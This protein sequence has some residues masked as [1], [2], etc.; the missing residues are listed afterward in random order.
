MLDEVKK[1]DSGRIR[2]LDGTG[3][4][5]AVA[6]KW[7]DGDETVITLIGARGMTVFESKY[8]GRTTSTDYP[9]G[10]LQVRVNA[11]GEGKGKAVAA[12]KI[13]YDKEKDSFRLDPYGNGATPIINV[14][15]NK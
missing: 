7:Q 9:F 13:K 10:F 6:E 1:L 14:R 8:R 15:P 12:A 3:N 11:K 5:I 2:T 4:P